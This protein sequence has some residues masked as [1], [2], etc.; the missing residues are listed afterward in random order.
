MS[1]PTSSQPKVSLP[2]VYQQDLFEEVC[3]QDQ[4][5]IL[6]RGLGLLHIITSLLHKYDAV[7][8]NLVLLIGADDRENGWL[9]EALAEHAARSGT[10]EARGLKIINTEV[11]SVSARAEM[12]KQGGIFS[13]TSRILVTDM[14]TDLIDCPKISGVVVLHSERVVAT[15]IEA[16]ILRI[17][18]QKNKDGFLKAFSDNPEPFTTGFAP[19][20]TMM[21]NLFLRSPSLWPRFHVT[22]A[23]SLETKKAEVIEIEAEMTD[24]MRE[25]QTAVLECIETSISEL[26]K[27][28]SSLELDDW[29]VDSALHKSFDVLIRRQLDPVWHR[30]SWKTKQIVN[31][32]TV[33]RRILHCLLTYDCVTFYQYLETILATH[34]PPPGS[35]RSS[36]SP[37]LFLDAAHTI[38]TL[39]KR[40]V[41]TGKADL[42][43]K[44]SGKVPFGLEPVL[45]ELPKWAI[46]A[47]VLDEI[48]K[49]GYFN[50]SHSQSSGSTLIMCSD[51]STCR[52]LREFVQTMHD[53]P[54]ENLKNQDDDLEKKPNRPSAAYMMRRKL[55]AYFAWKPDFAKLSALLYTGEP[56]NQSQSQGNFGGPSNNRP[57]SESFRGRA[58]PP[59]KR[60]RVRG[61][62]AAASGP[63]RQNAGA[64]QVTE[65]QSAQVAAL[66]AGVQPTEGEQN[67]KQEI[68]ADPFE[69][70]EDYYEFYEMNNLIVVHPY[71]GDMDE[72]LLDELRPRYVIMYEPDPAFIRRIEVYR[73]SHKDR[74]VRVYFLY[75][76]KSVEEQRY[77]SAVRKEK[78]SF[79]KLVREKGSMSVTL[80]LDAK[81]VEDPQEAFLR[82]VN[83]RIAGGGRL[84]ATAVP[85]RVIVDIREFRSS[86]PSLLHGRNVE[87]VP[88]TLTIGDYILSPDICVERKSIKDLIS[89]FKDGRLY[90]Q[91][92][93]MLLY[94]KNPMVLIEFDQNKSFNL[95]PFADL[96]GSIGQH[97]L[98]AKLVLLTIAFPK[99]KLI[100]SSSPYQTAE[101][102]E[103]LK[104]N[105]KEPDPLEA[106]KLGLE[107]GEEIAGAYNQTPQEILRSIPGINPKNIKLIMA[108]VDN[109]VELSNMEEKDISA[110]IGKE[111]GKLVHRFF[112]R[113]AF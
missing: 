26:R 10:P 100:W 60:R 18:R 47:E 74:E 73:S 35:T 67:V 52:Q 98:Q 111:A 88:C 9:G 70:M 54:L 5:V 91:C 90:T 78:D 25:I 105:Q 44:A 12:Y 80:T 17:Y 3:E 8:N 68:G 99:V 79:T 59:N 49:D 84:T 45:E 77:L 69:N 48:E 50:P 13:V 33:L 37:W 15:S 30:I 39:S 23:K 29:T 58:P 55:R 87:V 62:A 110:L 75:Y 66:L 82:T 51:Q 6:A 38:F 22:V 97:D 43:K 65:E 40:R 107:P 7:G 103:E 76:S 108:E 36:Q 42:S 93:N 106:I 19:L 1:A 72:R 24:S 86:L 101:I 14:L 94:Y 4:L 46:L 28:N 53:T 102:F 96:T 61:G 109:L 32:L 57:S 92:E 95:E 89:S 64:V 71:D 11:A 104:R 34:A 56:K 21:R 63:S 27:S 113:S 31:D 16:F 81:A 85:P 83:T 112:N 41:Y 2:L 20:A